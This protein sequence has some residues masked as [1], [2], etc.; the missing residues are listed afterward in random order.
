M[1]IVFPCVM[2]P[3]VT[4]HCRC[5]NMNWR[6]TEGRGVS[7]SQFMYLFALLMTKVTAVSMFV[8]HDWRGLRKRNGG[9]FTCTEL[10]I[11]VGTEC[12]SRQSICSTIVGLFVCLFVCFFYHQNYLF[13]SLFH[14]DFTI[15]QVK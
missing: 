8:T 13:H 6:R 11:H 1:T 2:Y 15:S 4:T 9:P 5:D 7:E 12:T 10:R 3:I 14:K